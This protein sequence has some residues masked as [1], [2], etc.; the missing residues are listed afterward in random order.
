MNREPKML[1]IR[2]I[3]FLSRR[4]KDTSCAI[5]RNCEAVLDVGFSRVI[6]IFALLAICDEISLRF[7]PI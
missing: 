3:V 5:V 2:I 7:L 4:R 1:N 6:L